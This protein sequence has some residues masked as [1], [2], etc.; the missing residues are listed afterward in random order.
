MTQLVLIRHGRT[1]WN[2]EE[3]M[4]GQT[5]VPLSDAGYQKI[6]QD[7]GSALNPALSGMYWISSPLKRA[8]TTAG[9]ICGFA[10]PLEPALMEM[11]WGAWEGQTLADI[12]VE[13]G[14]A[15]QI[16]EDK[17][18]D[19]RPTGGESPRDVQDRMK[20]WMASI[21]STRP[22][23]GAV[24]HKG[25]IRVV[26]AL[27]FDWNMMGKAPVKLDWAKAHIFQLDNS[28]QPR[29]LHMNVPLGHC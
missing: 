14:P 6:I 16:N 13:Q 27:A 10:P 22:G 4:Q 25:V 2:E 11:N 1:A 19:F 15:L 21:A 12:G 20:T 7:V 8:R 23:F 26:M 9:L 5:D 17:G 18:L 3:R 24:C 29:P 28:G